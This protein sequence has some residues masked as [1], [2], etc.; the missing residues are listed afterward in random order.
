M[1]PLTLIA[2][3]MVI[4]CSSSRTHFDASAPYPIKMALFPVIAEAPD[5]EVTLSVL[6]YLNKDGKVLDVSLAS[7]GIS[8]EWNAAAVDS[9]R[10]WT[11]SK[12]PQ[13]FKDEGMWVRRSV[14]VFFEDPIIMNIARIAIP[15]AAQADSVY[16]TL[17]YRSKLVDLFKDASKHHFPYTLEIEYDQ[18]LGVYPDHIRN[19]L[20]K[21]RIYTYT[22]PLKLDTDYVI[23]QRL[24][25]LHS[26]IPY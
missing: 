7:E 25:S 6:F 10:K 16:A 18:N 21:L 9:M 12:P 24:D 1:R 11:F 20:K 3:L 8:P 22:R 2:L 5:E 26:S 19:E 13:P 23:F 14:K 17:T 4:G 15:N